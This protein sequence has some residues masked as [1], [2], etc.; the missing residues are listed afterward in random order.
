[1]KTIESDE[2]LETVAKPG[3]DKMNGEF[4]PSGERPACYLH[5]GL[6]WESRE[7]REERR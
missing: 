2:W 6:P 3:A 1:M 5:T 7:E 4:F